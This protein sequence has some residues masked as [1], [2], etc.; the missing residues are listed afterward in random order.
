MR[1]VVVGGDADSCLASVRSW[2][3]PGALRKA[4]VGVHW[5]ENRWDRCRLV[6][7]LLC[8]CGVYSSRSVL[9]QLC[10]GFEV[11]LG[12]A[13]DLISFLESRTVSVGLLLVSVLSVGNLVDACMDAYGVEVRS[14]GRA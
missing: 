5:F 7:G 2:W 9:C 1:S 6:L 14:S 11:E 8:G 13:D 10:D 4:A 12:L 3:R